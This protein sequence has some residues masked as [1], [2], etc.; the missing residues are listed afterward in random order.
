MS[1]K[2]LMFLLR[3]AGTPGSE[4]VLFTSVT[5]QIRSGMALMKGVMREYVESTPK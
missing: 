5:G 1:R 4:M 3:T 2:V